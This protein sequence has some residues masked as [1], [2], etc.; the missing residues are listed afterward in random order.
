MFSVYL[1]AL[2][3]GKGSEG[4]GLNTLS[5]YHQLIFFS[6]LVKKTPVMHHKL[7]LLCLSAVGSIFVFC[8]RA[9][10]ELKLN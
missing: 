5:T 6:W 7:Q 9:E 10:F 4:G 1:Y 2:T 3:R 8:S